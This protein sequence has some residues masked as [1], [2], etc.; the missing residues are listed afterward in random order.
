LVINTNGNVESIS[1]TDPGVGYT[2]AT[3]TLTQTLGSG[4]NASFRPIISPW[5][6]HGSNPQQELFTRRVGITVSFD[7]DSQDL[8]TENDYRQVGLLKNITP[9]GSTTLFNEAT[10]S[11]SF[12]IGTSTPTSFAPDDN[13]TTD[14]EGEF[15]VTQVRDA[16]NDDTDDTIHLQEI[17]AGIAESDTLTNNTQD[18]TG[19]TINTGTLNN[20]EFDCKSGELLYYDNRKPIVRDE[21]Q[22]ET[23][24]LIFTF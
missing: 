3:I 21:D 5:G 19:L 23:V 16:N 18:I 22:V 4:T 2:K 6:G 10:G 1:I 9:Y 14:S 12:T 24:K 8:I 13:I 20:P 17:T 15:R 11:A 7:N